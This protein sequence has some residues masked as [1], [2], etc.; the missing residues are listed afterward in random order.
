MTGL[1]RELDTRGAAPADRGGPAARSHRRLRGGL[2][3]HG[4]RGRRRAG[5]SVRP[6][7]RTA[8]T[9]P[10]V[11]G[12]VWRRRRFSR[13]SGARWKT[14]MPC[15]VRRGTTAC[16]I[17]RTGS[18]CSTTSPSR[19]K[20]AFDA[21]HAGTG[22]GAGLGRPPRQRDQR[23]YSTTATDVLTISLHQE[24]ELPL[25][26]RRYRPARHRRGRGLQTSTCRCRRAV[27]IPATS[28]RWSAS[29]CR[30]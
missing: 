6:S 7:A 21:G 4:G 12:P 27:G 14:P 29:C 20:A 3:R 16:R 17:S 15:R 8:R 2:S 11:F 22:G 26:H 5:P 25:R 24:A 23:R 10:A 18:A 19:S 30:R 1:W 9:S 13:R 28:R